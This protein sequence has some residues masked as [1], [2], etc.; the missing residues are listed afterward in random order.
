MDCYINYFNCYQL[1]GSLIVCF[2]SFNNCMAKIGLSAVNIRVFLGTICLRTVSAVFMRTKTGPLWRA[3]TTQ[4]SC[5]QGR[6]VPYAG[7]VSYVR[8]SLF[9]Q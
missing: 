1:T 9:G 5:A 2:V 6:K 7:D 3:V 4:S 8:S